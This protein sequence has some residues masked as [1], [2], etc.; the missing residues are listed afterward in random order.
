[1]FITVK[2]TLDILCKF[3]RAKEN[4]KF[5]LY[6]PTGR[7]Q[8]SQGRFSLARPPYAI[9][10]LLLAT[11]SRTYDSRNCVTNSA[12]RVP[13]AIWPSYILKAKASGNLTFLLIY[14]I[15]LKKDFFMEQPQNKK[16]YSMQSIGIHSYINK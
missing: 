12:G 16:T 2:R 1:M 5:F 11:F 14:D 10:L 7:W 6:M 3:V 13:R 9:F 8:L 15:I 4:D